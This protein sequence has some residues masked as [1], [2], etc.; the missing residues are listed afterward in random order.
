MISEWVSE[1]TTGSWN[2]ARSSVRKG[3]STWTELFGG[4]SVSRNKRGSAWLT[5]S[6][7]VRHPV[8]I[9]HKVQQQQ[10]QRK[11]N[12]SAGGVTHPRGGHL[13]GARTRARWWAGCKSNVCARVFWFCLELAGEAALTIVT[14]SPAA[15]PST[16]SPHPSLLPKHKSK[17]EE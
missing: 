5:E 13:H 9:S 6:Q 16:P 7:D 12:K 4:R 17:Q 8:R 14:R 11:K 1:C 3:K 10:Q 15:H 2:H